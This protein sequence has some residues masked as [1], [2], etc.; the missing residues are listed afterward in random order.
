MPGRTRPS[1]SRH[2]ILGASGFLY[3]GR[4]LSH[5]ISIQDPSPCPVL[6]STHRY[7]SR[8]SRYSPVESRQ[9]AEP[10]C[11][12]RR[13]ILLFVYQL[14]LADEFYPMEVNL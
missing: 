11:R 13:G 1:E 9:G 4:K 3:V 10:V 6:P 12:S 2:R 5:P 8:T 14:E 7:P